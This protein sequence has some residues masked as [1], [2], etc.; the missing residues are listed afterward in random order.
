MD[1]PP[2][3]RSAAA[4]F[5]APTR[6]CLSSTRFLSCFHFP[7][8]VYSFSSRSAQEEERGL[9]RACVWACGRQAE[10]RTDGR[11][12]IIIFHVKL[13]PD[14]GWFETYVVIVVVL[15]IDSPPSQSPFHFPLWPFAYPYST[16]HPLS[17]SGPWK[18]YHHSIWWTPITQPRLSK[19]FIWKW[20]K[21]RVFCIRT[22]ADQTPSPPLHPSDPSPAPRDGSRPYW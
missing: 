3:S 6:A 2:L 8:L 14:N 19:L 5:P 17:M 7:P 9:R 15:T 20:I 18:S 1:P 16:I 22:F 13:T 4:T 12:T 10:R 21:V 11:N